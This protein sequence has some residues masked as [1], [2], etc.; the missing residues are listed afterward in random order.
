MAREEKGREGKDGEG[1]ASKYW[2]G[3]RWP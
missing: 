1:D 2:G 3:G